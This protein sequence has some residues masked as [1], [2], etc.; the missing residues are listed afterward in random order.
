MLK[1][2]DF[3]LTTCDMKYCQL[4]VKR[5]ILN[6]QKLLIFGEK[7]RSTSLQHSW[8][9]VIFYTEVKTSMETQYHLN[10]HHRAWVTYPCFCLILSEMYFKLG[11]LN[12]ASTYTCCSQKAKCLYWSVL[13]TSFLNCTRLSIYTGYYSFKSI[14]NSLVDI[15][16][17]S[18]INPTL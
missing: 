7:K 13:S 8:K 14:I 10:W 9:T 15:T 11:K 6:V 1:K 4:F 16:V 17:T 18:F 2:P 12:K 3:L 5:V